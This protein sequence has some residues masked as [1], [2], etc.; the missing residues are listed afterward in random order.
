MTC[1]WLV[2]GCYL[3]EAQQPRCA[4]GNSIM[5]VLGQV[6]DAALLCAQPITP[7]G[8]CRKLSRGMADLMLEAD[9]L[10]TCQSAGFS[11]RERGV[12]ENS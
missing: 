1:S 10:F 8:L 7:V 3:V 11:W 9:F 12:R 4:N 5:M 2:T 6:D